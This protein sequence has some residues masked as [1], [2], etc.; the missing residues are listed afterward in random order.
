MVDTEN[1][2]EPAEVSKLQS[3]GEQGSF[4]GH[5]QKRVKRP[6]RKFYEIKHSHSLTYVKV[7]YCRPLRNSTSTYGEIRSVP[8][9][10]VTDLSAR[11][12]RLMG[13]ADRRTQYPSPAA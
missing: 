6:V 3:R 8:T 1:V 10:H 2:Q 4:P 13:Y 5:G 11:L 9:K 7:P 12:A